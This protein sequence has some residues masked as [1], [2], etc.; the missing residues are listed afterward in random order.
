MNWCPHCNLFTF[1]RILSVDRDRA[2][3][4]EIDVEMEKSN[5]LN[6]IIISE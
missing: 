5:D 1:Y 4:I 6:L 3:W 2:V